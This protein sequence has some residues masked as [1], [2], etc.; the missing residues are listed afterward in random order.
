MTNPPEGRVFQKTFN[1]VDLCKEYHL[2]ITEEQV[3]ALKVYI[4]A[5]LFKKST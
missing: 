1:L 3:N 2:T 5:L 4:H